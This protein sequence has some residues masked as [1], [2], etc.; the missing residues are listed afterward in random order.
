MRRL[1]EN[2]NLLDLAEGL[3]GGHPGSL[4]TTIG[5]GGFAAVALAMYGLMCVLAQEATF[6][7]SRPVKIVRY[8]GTP[9]VCLGV[10][11][12]AVAVFMHSHFMWSSSERFHVLGQLGK[13]LSAT[14][15]ATAI[16]YL[17][18]YVIAFT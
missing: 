5:L 12:V 1:N 11:Y 16:G 17:V 10:A 7:G 14:V 4:F 3:A 8:S 15:V 6:I 13:L 9:A 2:R 18:Y